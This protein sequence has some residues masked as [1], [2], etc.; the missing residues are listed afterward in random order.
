[1]WTIFPLVTSSLGPQSGR[2]DHRRRRRPQTRHRDHRVAPTT[3]TLCPHTDESAATSS[4]G[5]PHPVPLAPLDPH[6]SR[7]WIPAGLLLGWDPDRYP[8]SSTTSRSGH[9]YPSRCSRATR[10]ALRY[11]QFVVQDSTGPSEEGKP[12]LAML[13]T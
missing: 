11:P 2:A 5:T 7:Q 1:M 12:D 6:S 4:P 13:T 8:A 3:T 10:D 9:P